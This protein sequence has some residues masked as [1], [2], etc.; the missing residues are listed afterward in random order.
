MSTPDPTVAQ[1]LQ[2]ERF[3]YPG[4]LPREIIVLRAWLRLRE[5]DYDRFDYN[6]RIGTGFDPGRRRQHNSAGALVIR[7]FSQPFLRGW[8]NPARTSDGSMRRILSSLCVLWHE[9]C[10][11]CLHL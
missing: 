8:G 7:L 4:L 6:V 9:P 11:S 5:K 10:K 1:L 2:S 3:K